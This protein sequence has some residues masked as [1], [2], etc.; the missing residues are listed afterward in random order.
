MKYVGWVGQCTFAC[1]HTVF[2]VRDKGTVVVFNG[3]A[4][5]IHETSG[6]WLHWIYCLTNVCSQIGMLWSTKRS[7]FWVV[8]IMFF[9][10]LIICLIYQ[11]NVVNKWATLSSSTR[12]VLGTQS[13]ECSDGSVAHGLGDRFPTGFLLGPLSG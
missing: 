3:T 11:P 6:L 12:C 8:N 5:L 7:F 13:V 2:C 10:C 1:L 9:V 4:S